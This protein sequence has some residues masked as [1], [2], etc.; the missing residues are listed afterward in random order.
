VPSEVIGQRDAEV[1]VYFGQPIHEFATGLAGKWALNLRQTL[2][3][4]KRFGVPM[5][6]LCNSRGATTR[7]GALG[8]GR[9]FLG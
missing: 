1:L 5:E 3:L 2:A 7:Q 9:L 4:A 6:A 8:A